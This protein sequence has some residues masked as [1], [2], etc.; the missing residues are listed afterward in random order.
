M[1]WWHHRDI[2]IYVPLV[3]LCRVS[4]PP[5]L[6]VREAEELC[7]TRNNA[8]L[9]SWGSFIRESRREHSAGSQRCPPWWFSQTGLA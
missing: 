4:P 2:S 8:T 9:N 3:R 1:K 7:L 6:T 5:T